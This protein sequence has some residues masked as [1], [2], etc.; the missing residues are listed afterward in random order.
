M[1]Y[2]LNLIY[3]II[4]R[5]L[6]GHNSIWCRYGH[7]THM[8]RHSWWCTPPSDCQ[9][10]IDHVKFWWRRWESWGL[11]WGRRQPTTGL[12][13]CVAIWLDEAGTLG[14]FYEGIKVMLRVEPAV[15]TKPTKFS[16]LI[17]F[18]I[19][20]GDAPGNQ[21]RPLHGRHQSLW[22]LSMFIS[23]WELKK[24]QAIRQINHL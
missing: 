3:F 9:I 5:W 12:P 22:Y 20:I 10:F 16:S 18:D 8:G 17:N 14:P 2:L 19:I 21:W 23:H 4:T 24:A 15:T 13:S 11:G 7:P 1:F 6:K